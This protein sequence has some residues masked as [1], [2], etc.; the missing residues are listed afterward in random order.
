MC[1]RVEC[2]RCRAIQ[3]SPILRNSDVVAGIHEGWPVSDLQPR[4]HGNSPQGSDERQHDHENSEWTREYFPWGQ[5]VF[6]FQGN[7]HF[8]CPLPSRKQDWRLYST[9]TWRLLC[10][11]QQ[12]RIYNISDP[13]VV[14]GSKNSNITHNFSQPSTSSLLRLFGKKQLSCTLHLLFLICH[15][16]TSETQNSILYVILNSKVL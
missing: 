1:P 13:K 11:S 2:L 7:I 16:L 15:F 14:T 6:Y 4:V 5:G 12:V 9:N 8:T 10:S 3:V